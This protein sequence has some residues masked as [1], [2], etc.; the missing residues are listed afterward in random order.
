MVLAR[1]LTS[2]ILDRNTDGSIIVF[3]DL[4]IEFACSAIGLIKGLFTIPDGSIW[5]DKSHLVHESE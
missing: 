4:E 2:S 3:I 5:P 1:C